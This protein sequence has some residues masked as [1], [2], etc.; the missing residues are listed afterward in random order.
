MQDLIEILITIRNTQKFTYY[1]FFL[2]IFEKYL[3]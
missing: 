1:L 2:L 3:G